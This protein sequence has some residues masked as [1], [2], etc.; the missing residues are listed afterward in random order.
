VSD[1]YNVVHT[2]LTCDLHEKPMELKGLTFRH[3]CLYGFSIEV[4]TSCE[5]ECTKEQEI[6]DLSEDQFTDLKHILERVYIT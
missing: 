5:H 6:C 1:P 4:K 2:L 3:S